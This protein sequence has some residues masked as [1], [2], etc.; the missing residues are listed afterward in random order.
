MSSLIVQ[1]RQIDAINPHNN[2]DRLELL[3]VGGWQIISEKGLHKVGE[4]VVYVP[5]DSI[6]PKE[7]SDKLN[8]TNYLSNGRVK[9][10]KLRGE[11]SFGVLLPAEPEWEIGK[12]VADI[13][14]IVKYEPPV[15]QIKFRGPPV[16]SIPANPLFPKYTDIENLRNFSDAFELGEL[17]EFTEKI[18]GSNVRIAQI[19]GEILAGSHNLNWKRP[20]E[21][22]LVDNWYWYP[23]TLE[24]VKNCFKDYKNNKNI[25]IYGEVYG[26][27]QN[28]NY[29]IPGK[30]AFTAFDM[31]IDGKYV[32]RTEFDIICNKYGIP[33]VPSLYT[34]PYSMERVK[35][36]STGLTVLGNG[37]NIREGIVIRPTIERY[38]KF[39]RVIYKYLNDDYLIKKESGKITDS[40]DI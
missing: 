26:K 4:K 15:T 28:L 19:D 11:P 34:G 6:L 21:E 8:I 39:G 29:G 1:V 2:A 38:N 10:I 33:H 40:T 22:N 23:T 37:F 16:D 27:V 14:S 25:V 12:D 30:I 32:D 9:C 36:H 18:H 5:P 17:V 31:I 20:L 7:L 13:F 3:T 24:S 35:E